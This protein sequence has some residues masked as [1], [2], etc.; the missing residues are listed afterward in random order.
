MNFGGWDAVF[1]LCILLLWAGVWTLGSAEA[2]FNAYLKAFRDG[3]VSALAV[4]RPAFYFNVP[5]PLIACVCIVLLMLARSLLVP[6]EPQWTIPVGFLSLSLQH[7]DTWSEALVF[8][9]LSSCIFLFKFWALAVL[10]LGFGHDAS[11]SAAR[12]AL[13]RLAMPLSRLRPE[14]RPIALLAMGTGLIL[15]LGR[16]AGGET[17]TLPRAILSALAAWVGTLDALRLTLFV[18]IVGSWVA[19][20][21]GSNHIAWMCNDWL[22]LL[23]GPA[24]RFPV[25]VGMLDLTPLL[26]FFGLALLQFV[27]VRL[28]VFAWQ[29]LPA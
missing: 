17:P 1:N 2:V 14:V 5:Y 3:L 10:Y 6:R 24:R 19:M 12:V 25:R 26:F 21:S 15:L 18:L 16:I 23:L 28:L 22:E 13:R 7:V 8:G 9:A 29:G 4:V 11:A 20:A 27:L